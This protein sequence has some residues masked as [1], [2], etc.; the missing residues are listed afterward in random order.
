MENCFELELEYPLVPERGLCAFQIYL[1]IKQNINNDTLRGLS[2]IQNCL[3]FCKSLKKLVKVS[4]A[5]C[6]H[7]PYPLTSCFRPSVRVL[8]VVHTL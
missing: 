8:E 2:H 4:S 5:S 3:G 1:M 7:T 6:F